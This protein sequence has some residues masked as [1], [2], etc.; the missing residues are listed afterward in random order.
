MQNGRATIVAAAVRRVFLRAKSP[1]T[2][3]VFAQ[4]QGPLLNKQNMTGTAWQA[5]RCQVIGRRTATRRLYLEG[6]R[7][8]RLGGKRACDTRVR[9]GIRARD[10]RAQRCLWRRQIRLKKSQDGALESGRAPA[11]SALAVFG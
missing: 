1:A 6:H 11:L 5:G 10:G 7:E 9:G 4:H 8:R 3:R 2:R